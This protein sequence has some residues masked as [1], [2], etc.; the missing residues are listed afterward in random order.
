MGV[1]QRVARVCL[2]QMR[3]VQI[4][5]RTDSQTD[6]QTDKLTRLSR[7]I[8]LQK[9]SAKVS[10]NKVEIDQ[11]MT[12]DFHDVIVEFNSPVSLNQAEW[13]YIMHR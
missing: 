7:E 3:L 8:N 1:R 10:P 5:E 2:R 12:I 13:L 6:K 4:C 11:I 9:V